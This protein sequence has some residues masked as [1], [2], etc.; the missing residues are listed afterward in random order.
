VKVVRERDARRITAAEKKYMRKTA[1]HTGTDYKTNTDIA[2][3]LN[4]TQVLYK[5][6]IYIPQRHFL[7]VRLASS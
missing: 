5:I 2:K 7:F 1:G 6:F 4:V 3:G